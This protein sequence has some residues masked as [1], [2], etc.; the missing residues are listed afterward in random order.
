MLKHVFL[1][2][3]AMTF[4]APYGYARRIK[5]SARERYRLSRAVLSSLSVTYSGHLGIIP[6]AAASIK[7][8][9]TNA[10]RG[11]EGSPTLSF[12]LDVGINSSALVFT[13]RR[14]Q[15][16]TG[17]MYRSFAYDLDADSLY[18]D[19]SDLITKMGAKGRFLTDYASFPLAVRFLLFNLGPNVAIVPSFSLGLMADM[20]LSSSFESIVY[21][22]T[23]ALTRLSKSFDLAGFLAIGLDYPIK[24]GVLTFRFSYAI[25]FT[26]TNAIDVKTSSI[27]EYPWDFRI[28]EYR[29]NAM[30]VAFM[31]GYTI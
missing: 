10:N 14:I 6:F 18:I 23:I 17:V 13:D 21:S 26:Q 3:L 20:M 9:S 29:K 27:P 16:L 30:H 12:G 28:A 7:P 19:P 8:T 5:R 2:V 24:K 22:K 1:F 31:Y 15:I 4:L 25:G 11:M